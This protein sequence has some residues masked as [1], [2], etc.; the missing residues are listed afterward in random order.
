LLP[1]IPCR[2][3][4]SGILVHGLTFP[5]RGNRRNEMTRKDYIKFADMLAHAHAQASNR[6]QHSTIDT[7]TIDLADILAGDNGRF[8]RQRFYHAAEYCEW[9]VQS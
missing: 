2:L 3:T 6:V 8:D 5:D 1:F 9:E 7:L 4:V